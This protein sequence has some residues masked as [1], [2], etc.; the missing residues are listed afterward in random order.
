MSPGPNN[1]SIFQFPPFCSEETR[2]LG[3]FLIMPSTISSIS[4]KAL[5]YNCDQIVFCCTILIDNRLLLY[6]V[7]HHQ[8]QA[9]CTN[10]C[11][12]SEK[13]PLKIL[14]LQVF[15]SPSGQPE[16]CLT[17]W[18]KRCRGLLVRA[19]IVLMVANINLINFILVPER[20][21]EAPVS[22]EA[23]IARTA[24]AEKF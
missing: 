21:F 16:P 20:T 4:C 5:M 18:K 13:V 15:S 19:L 9:N 6:N 23:E 2:W 7:H 11:L 14:H 12:V 10:V 22:R 1:S 17:R 8:I 24:F 3:I